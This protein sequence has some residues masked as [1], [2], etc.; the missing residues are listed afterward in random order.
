MK[1]K[2]MNRAGLL[3]ILSA[4]MALLIFVDDSAAGLYALLSLFFALLAIPFS[5]PARGK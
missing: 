4:F 5:L 1:Q 3:S 2:N